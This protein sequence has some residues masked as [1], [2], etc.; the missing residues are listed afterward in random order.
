MSTS[1]KTKT[2]PKCKLEFSLQDFLTRSD[3]EPIGLSTDFNGQGDCYFFFC[4]NA[5]ECMTT[6]TIP[7]EFFLPAITE[8]I[9]HEQ[10][11]LK[12]GC[13][14]HCTTIADLRCCGCTCYQA[15]FR[16][17]MLELIKSRETEPT[18]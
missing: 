8:G 5:P 1:A 15:P 18:Y 16:R 11:L 13:P 14:R 2:C 12:A 9:P 3:I 4:H 17:F 6:L 7:M 10:K